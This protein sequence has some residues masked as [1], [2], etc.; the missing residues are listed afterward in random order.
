M[1][2]YIFLT[3][4]IQHVGGGQCYVASKA[5]YLESQ[6]WNVIV[7]SSGSLR[8]KIKC[9]IDYLNKFLDYKFVEFNY[10]VYSLSHLIVDRG[11]NR[12]L[13]M[14]GKYDESEEIIIESHTDVTALWGEL[15]AERMGARHFY[16]AMY[17]HYRWP[18]RNFQNKMDFYQFKMDR[19]EILCC[20]RTINR[21]FEGYRE[22][23]EEDIE[24]FI[25]DEA[26]VQ[27]VACEKVDSIKMSDYNICYIGRTHKLY[28]PHIINGVGEFSGN[29]RDKQIQL[30]IVGDADKQRDVIEEQKKQH[31]NLKVT[32]I[33]SLHPLPRSLYSKID[34]VIAG[35]GSARCSVDEGALT[36]I[37]DIES[38]KSL[39]ILG[40]DTNDSIYRA[41][42]SVVTTYADA[43]ERV[44]I[45]QVYKKMS[46]KYPKKKSV[47]ETTSQNF[48][49]MNKASKEKEYFEEK[50]IRQGKKSL[51]A[52]INYIRAILKLI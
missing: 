23:K 5:K 20:S 47:A 50:E 32:E 48:S 8:N 34:V 31:P 3:F 26:P 18:E 28:V 37:A 12:I 6:G 41:K 13:K 39:G 35:S 27:D 11:L 15:L 7:M 9:P 33:G 29:H 52:N 21:L 42:D 16:I 36:I 1:K 14:M 25:I 10:Q 17:E 51:R 44:L 46:F 4:P 24:P 40:Y 49:I 22:Y 45:E 2:T 19:N 30:V 43:L 38:D